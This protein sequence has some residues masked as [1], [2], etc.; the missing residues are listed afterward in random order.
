MNRDGITD[1]VMVEGL[2]TCDMILRALDGLTGDSVWEARLKYDAFAVKCDI[3]LNDD[4]IIDCI[5]AGR[6]SGFRALSGADGS[7]L[8]DRDPNL[9]YLR[10]NFYFP[11]IVPDLDY[12]GVP[13][14]VN[15]HGGDATYGESVTERSPSFL[16]VV[17]GRTGQQLMERVP[18]PDGHET[19]MSP[20]YL[21]RGEGLDGMIL[22]GTGGETLPGSLWAISYNSLRS[23]ILRYRTTHTQYDP[24]YTPFREYINHACNKD[25]T[26]KELEDLRPVFDPESFDVGRDTKGDKHLSLC[27]SWGSHHAIW[28]EYGLC[29]YQL[30][31]TEEKGVMLPPVIVDMTEDA[32]DDLVVSTFDGRTLVINGNDTEVVWE[33][34]RPGTESYRCVCVC[35]HVHVC[36]HVRACMCVC[37]CV[38]VCV[39]VCVCVCVY[40]HISTLAHI[41]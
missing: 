34:T 40:S 7:I 29:V 28:N 22:V 19:Y 31:T 23:R 9:A 26:T 25:M 10:Y 2:G 33:V 11:L 30:L 41:N 38:R 8:W 13:D 18:V 14:L 20:V 5:A 39:C 15:T 32:Q 1:V 37:V 35:M 4:D 12:D 3:D 36:V 17:S 24:D 27:R 6:Q 21:S 16:V